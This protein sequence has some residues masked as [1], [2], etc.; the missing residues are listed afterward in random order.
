[1]LDALRRTTPVTCAQV[2]CDRLLR[3]A[4][5]SDGTVTPAELD[6]VCA[7]VVEEAAAE[8]RPVDPAIA[9]A[10]RRRRQISE[11]LAALVRAAL[12]DVGDRRTL[13]LDVD[14]LRADAAVRRAALEYASARVR[15]SA[16]VSGS[17]T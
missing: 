2:V 9:P 11:C 1:V 3:G 14:R 12:V 8:G 7:A 16:V 4:E 15:S 6:R 17:P 10:P 5:A 13:V